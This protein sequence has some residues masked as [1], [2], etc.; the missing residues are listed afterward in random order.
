MRE[1]AKSTGSCGMID[2]DSRR[3]WSETDRISIPSIKM[4][5]PFSISTKRKRVN[6]SDDLPEP[7]RPTTPR[8]DPGG[9]LILTFLRASG[10]TGLYLMDTSLNSMFPFH[11][12][13]LATSAPSSK[14]DKVIFKADDSGYMETSASPGFANSFGIFGLLSDSLKGPLASSDSK[15]VISSNRETLI[16][17]VSR[18]AK[19][20]TPQFIKPVIDKA[21]VTPQPA[22]PA[23]S[24]P[25]RDKNTHATAEAKTTM[26]PRV[27]I[28]KD[29]HLSTVFDV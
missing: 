18:S 24:F 17:P 3:V 11:G 15:S 29:N 1:P 2:R 7:V 25:I 26:F 12:H 8:V 21:C 4:V 23:F 28:R 27:S 13:P 16:M 14:G 10:D 22:E 9:T 20:R 19:Q 6:N 5:P